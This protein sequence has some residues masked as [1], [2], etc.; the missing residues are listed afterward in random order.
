MSRNTR[1]LS[2][3]ICLCTVFLCVFSACAPEVQKVENIERIDC[4][5]KTYYSFDVLKTVCEDRVYYVIAKANR[6][7]I[8]MPVKIND[9]SYDNPF[10]DYSHPMHGVASAWDSYKELDAS[11]YASL[12]RYQIEEII[13][14]H[15]SVEFCEDEATLFVYDVPLIT[16]MYALGLINTSAKARAYDSKKWEE[17]GQ[18]FEVKTIKADK[19]NV[20]II[21]FQ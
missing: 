12:H 1:I 17:I 19:E 6:Y 9:I 4:D 20:K 16:T 3:L 8:G 21:P 7:R 11:D 5:G 10:I 13:P 14:Y 18:Y 2:L 15:I